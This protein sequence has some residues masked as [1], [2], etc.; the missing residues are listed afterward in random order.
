MVNDNRGCM[1]F[2]GFTNATFSKRNPATAGLPFYNAFII[3]F[4]PAFQLAMGNGQLTKA[5]GF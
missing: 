5:A 1:V 4:N 2:R 3:F